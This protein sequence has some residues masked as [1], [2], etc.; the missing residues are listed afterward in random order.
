MTSESLHDP[1]HA[2]YGVSNPLSQSLVP[3][4]LHSHPISIT[5]LH[6]TIRA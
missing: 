2:L 6:F 4:I 5:F 1:S 3:C